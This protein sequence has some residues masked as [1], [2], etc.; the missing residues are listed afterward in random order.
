MESLFVA[1]IVLFGFGFGARSISDNSTFVH[2]RT[3]IDLVAGRGFP[4][5]DPYSFT[6]HG[7]AWVLQS[8]LP[9]LFYGVAY[10]LGRGELLVIEQAVLTGGLAWLLVRLARTGSAMPTAL[11]GLIA[12]AIG[13]PFWSPRPLLFG[14]LCLT[15][16]VTIVENRWNRWWLVPVVWVWVSSHGSFPLGLAWLVARLVGERLDRGGMSRDTLRYLGAFVVGLGVAALNPAGPRLL[17]FWLAIGS[18]REVFRTIVEWHS[19]DF[20]SGAGLFSL[21]FL[22]LALVILVRQAVPWADLLGVV[23]FIALGLIAMRNITAAAV[24]I[25]PALGHAMRASAPPAVPLSLANRSSPS[26]PDL[27]RLLFGGL[28]LLFAVFATRPYL[29]GNP[30]DVRSYPVAAASFIHGQGLMQPPHHVVEQ[31]IVGGYLILV[32]GRHAQVFVDDRYDMYPLSVSRAYETLLR[33][34]PGSLDVLNRLSADVVLWD[35]R[36]PLV[37]TLDASGRWHHSYEDTRWVVL[38]RNT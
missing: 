10:R 11:A 26:S 13:A 35:R 33:G 9:E 28:V 1:A 20:Q 16:T 7:H 18:K 29:S 4:R 15:L 24:V 22:S 6:A 34:Y 38:Q 31:D 8:W 19:P 32:Y 21:V 36:Q 3:G 17:T 5:T 37:A 2:L 23:G 30:I 27:N 25:A 14:L 12:V